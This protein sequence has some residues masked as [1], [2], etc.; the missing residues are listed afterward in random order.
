MMQSPKLATKMEPSEKAYPETLDNVDKMKT[1][2]YDNIHGLAGYRKSA[3]TAQFKNPLVVVYYD[4]DYVKNPK[5]SNY[6]RNRV[7]KAAK[8]L[9]E[10]GKKI[11][12]AVSSS[13]EMSHE[14]SEYGL[15]PPTDKPVVA[16]RDADDQKFVLS[17][18][19]SIEALQKFAVDLLEG[20]LEPHMKSEP[21]PTSL[22]G[23]VQVLVAKNFKEIVDDETKDVLIEFYAP[24]CGHCKTLAPKYEELAEMLK[25]EKD[26]VIAKMDA[27]ANDVPKI[28]DVKGF[29]TLY[30]SPKGA[31][32]NPKRYEGGREVDDFMKY[33]AKE[34]TDPLSG[35]DRNGKKQK[36]KTEL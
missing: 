11:Q 24:W 8:E 7:I 21:V 4:V 31:K 32:K 28:Y 14:L 15:T 2:L 9:S 29:P 30:W 1:W 10:Q 33:I 16:G 13:S 5:G 12:F 35:Y 6:W 26:I 19:F 36:K 17:G 23:H 22:D 3:N 20:K 18:E 27:T 25:D 34:A